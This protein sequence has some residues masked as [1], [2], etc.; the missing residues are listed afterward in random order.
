MHPKS[1]LRLKQNQD[2][3]WQFTCFLLSNN[4]QIPNQIEIQKAGNLTTFQKEQGEHSL[5]KPTEK[6]IP[7]QT[8]TFFEGRKCS[9]RFNY[10]LSAIQLD[11]PS[12]PRFVLSPLKTRPGSKRKSLTPT[13]VN[14]SSCIWEVN[15]LVQAERRQPKRWEWRGVFQQYGSLELL[16]RN[17]CGA[18]V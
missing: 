11:V 2:G 10:I 4:V 13:K 16:K 18:N 12:T 7:V 3:I 8:W 15:D 6:A 9:C 17:V 14:L 1:P 5:V